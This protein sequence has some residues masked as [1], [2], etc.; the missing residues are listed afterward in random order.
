MIRGPL[1]LW[2]A[3]LLG[4]YIG[5]SAA[6]YFMERYLFP[7]SP[8]LAT[9]GGAWALGWSDRVGPGLRRMMA[10]ALFLVLMA[11]GGHVLTRGEANRYRAMTEWVET[12]VGEDEWVAAM[13]SGAIGFHHD[14]TLNLDGKVNPAAL[15]AR[16]AGRLDAYVRDPGPAITP[17]PRYI[18]GWAPLRGWLERPDIEETFEEVPT[19]A[20]SHLAVLCRRP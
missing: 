15:A 19:P 3:L 14:R 7:L 10:G 13:Q 17:A 20:V 1:L 6:P 18:V 2:P 9:V 8:F 16:R 11:G 12:H 4:T 5:W